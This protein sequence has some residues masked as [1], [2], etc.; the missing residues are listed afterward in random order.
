M[1]VHITAPVWH[2]NLPTNRKMVLLKLADCANQH[3]A[4]A[5]PSVDT[6]ARDTGVSRRTVQTI[7]AEFRSSDV[8]VVERHEKGGRG[9]ST[10]YKIDLPSSDEKLM[11]EGMAVLSDFAF[12]ML[13]SDEEVEAEKGV[14]DGEERER[15]SAGFRVFEQT[16]D[17]LYAGTR[18]A[19]R[20]PIGTKS[21]R[22]AFTGQMVRDF[23]KRWYRP[24]ISSSENEPG[25]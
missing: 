17:R 5:F 9:L 21:V 2:L 23:Y 16:L 10:V 24:E 14:I 3:G 7:L 8:L 25:P 4:N 19:E 6:I 12:R 15:D 11:G 13:L 18:Y 1:S 22:D 20:M